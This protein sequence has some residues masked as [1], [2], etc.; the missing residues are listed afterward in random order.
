M[1]AAM[2]CFRNNLQVFESVIVRVSVHMMD[3]LVVIETW[4]ISHITN[5]KLTHYGFDIHKKDWQV[6]KRGV[7]VF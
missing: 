4:L 3:L 1:E 7:A 5:Q 6:L 2:L